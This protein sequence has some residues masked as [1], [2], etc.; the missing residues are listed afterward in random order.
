MKRD[1]VDFH[2][3]SA[4]HEVIHARLQNWAASV[5]GRHRNSVAP[6]FRDYRS[7]ARARDQ[8]EA[9]CPIDYGDARRIGAAVTM[10]PT[11]NR[12]AIQWS[13]VLRSSPTAGRKY[14][15][16]TTD[17]LQQYVID[18]RQMLVNRGV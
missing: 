16:C 11:R 8:I 5:Q 15:G 13:Y 14:V 2:E 18:A 17:E 7:P 1:Y 10:L 12:M 3:V 6:M 4:A 9:K